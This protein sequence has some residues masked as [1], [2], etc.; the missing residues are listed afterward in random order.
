M[1][2]AA[3]SYV[4]ST[5]LVCDKD[6][7]APP[8]VQCMF[9]KRAGSLIEHCDAGHS[10]HLSQTT[11][12]VTRIVKTIERVVSGSQQDTPKNLASSSVS[13]EN[14]PSRNLPPRSTTPGNSGKRSSP[15]RDSPPRGSPST[16]SPPRGGHRKGSSKEGSPQKISLRATS[17]IL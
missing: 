1:T 6:K 3:Y 13:R 12:L 16:G 4:P 15:P 2:R 9:A 8:E 7:A 5:Y 10:P 14:S 17:R 11:M